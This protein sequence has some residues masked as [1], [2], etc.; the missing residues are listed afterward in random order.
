MARVCTS[1]FSEAYN[2]VGIGT[3]VRGYNKGFWIG[4]GGCGPGNG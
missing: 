2:A 1:R 4:G 3:S